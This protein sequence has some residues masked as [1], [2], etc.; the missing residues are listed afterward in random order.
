M[1][2]VWCFGGLGIYITRLY[3]FL[4]II[5]LELVKAKLE[6]SQRKKE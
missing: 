2:G 3:V 4:A 5:L 6:E 1:F